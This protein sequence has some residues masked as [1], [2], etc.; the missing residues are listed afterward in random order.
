MLFEYTPNTVAIQSISHPSSNNKYKAL[1]F[2]SRLI[3]RYTMYIQGEYN[4]DWEWVG[5]E[6]SVLEIF[7]I[8]QIFQIF[9]DFQTATKRMG[10]EFPE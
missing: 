2:M 8:F 6:E 9:H 5:D 7:Q 10:Q 3:V 4:N 1:C